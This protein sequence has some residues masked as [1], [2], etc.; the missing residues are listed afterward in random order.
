M[1][2][3][4]L[5]LKC[6]KNISLILFAGFLF[7]SC[8]PSHVVH[9]DS[10]QPALQPPVEAVSYQSFYDQLSPYGNWINY[11]GYGYVWSPNA[12][13]D[14]RPY[15]SNG[16][17][18]YTDAGWTWASN[19][20]W[21]WAPFHYGRWFFEYGYGWMWIPGNEWAP[22]WVSWRGNGD[23]YGWAPMGPHVSVEMAMNNYSPP[24]NYWNFVPCR[25]MGNPGWHQY[26]VNES[27][28]V[29]IIHNTT[30]IN[31]YYGSHSNSHAYTLGPDPNEVRR[32]SG[33]HFT[34]V[35]I[36]ESGSPGERV[37]G[38]QYVVYRP[39]VNAYPAAR[40]DAAGLPSTPA[41]ARYQPY[42][43][44]RPS[45]QNPTENQQNNAQPAPVRPSNT[46]PANNHPQNGYNT[47]TADQNP[48]DNQPQNGNNAKPIIPNPVNNQPQP[49]NNSKP[50]DQNN[51]ITHP[52]SGNDP[53]PAVQNWNEN[54]SGHPATGNA[55]PVT[56][57]NTNQPAPANHTQ[58]T[59]RP[60]SEHNPNN[61]K[62]VQGAVRTEN[63]PVTKP[64]E[65]PKTR[66]ADN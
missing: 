45:T 1:E 33:N 43:N 56:S 36:H 29:T 10:Y 52:Q 4:D 32:V 20:N 53:R 62:P 24:S 46:N 30:I 58:T 64:E 40:G 37:S 8:G 57:N 48:T 22:A 34:E 39:R 18:I 6:M 49:V 5:K 31:N 17:W 12:G 55:V 26:Y 60:S 3:P 54:H 15:S 11:P 13:S 19:Y 14:F 61:G 16:N 27:R 42:S 25:Y 51:H 2:L 59:G 38:T 66:E 35:Q 7:T 63:K 9:E 28:N 41:P 21:G 23:Y 65:K 44:A 50:A 47:R